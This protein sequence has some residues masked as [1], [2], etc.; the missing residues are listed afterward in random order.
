MGIF[1]HIFFPNDAKYVAQSQQL[2]DLER[3]ESFEENARRLAGDLQNPINEALEM[4]ADDE[5][6]RVRRCPR[7]CTVW[8]AS[9]FVAIDIKERNISG[10]VARHLESI[11]QPLGYRVS[12]NRGGRIFVSLP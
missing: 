11:Y 2:A 10:K 9:R 1:R 7:G 3:Q 4:L 6:G 5:S 12:R 8:A